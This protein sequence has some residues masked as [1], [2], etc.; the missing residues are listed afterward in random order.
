MTDHS[1]SR[2]NYEIKVKGMFSAK[3]VANDVILKI[4]TPKNAAKF[5]E[6]TTSGGKAKYVPVSAENIPS[7]SASSRSPES[8]ST[9]ICGASI[10][11]PQFDVFRILPFTLLRGRTAFNGK[12][13]NSQE[14]RL[15]SSKETLSLW[16]LS[17]RKCGLDLP[18]LLIS[19]YTLCRLVRYGNSDTISQRR[20]RAGTALVPARSF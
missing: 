14:M 19:R 7:A 5:N 1:Q 17:T 3:L 12:S 6:I 2:V 11:T 16:P 8:I 10:Q 18:S 15:S 20:L 4:P 13:R 9:L